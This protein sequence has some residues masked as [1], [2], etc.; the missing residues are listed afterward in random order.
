[1]RFADVEDTIDSG[2]PAKDEVG[3]YVVQ[4]R[5][6]RRACFHPAFPTRPLDLRSS[7]HALPH[8]RSPIPSY[9]SCRAAPQSARCCDHLE[10]ELKCP[11]E[12][13]RTMPLLTDDARHTSPWRVLDA[14][15]YEP[16]WDV[17]SSRYGPRDLSLST[18]CE[19]HLRVSSVMHERVLI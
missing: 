18:T 6:W 11:V 10:L 8:L 16:L 7:W 14:F 17:P 12:A 9:T 3:R 1:M 19:P 4:S 13:S 15:L 5:V 2:M